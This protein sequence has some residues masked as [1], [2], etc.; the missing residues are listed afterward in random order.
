MATSYRPLPR[1]HSICPTT[2]VLVS[3]PNT[4]KEG[5]PEA[6]DNELRRVWASLLSRPFLTAF[7]AAW[8]FFFSTAAKKKLREGLG[9]RLGLV[10]RLGRKCVHCTWHAGTLS[11]RYYVMVM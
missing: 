9:T 6:S 7:F 3:F 5:T 1:T 8:N 10:Y 4:H 11:S 2:S